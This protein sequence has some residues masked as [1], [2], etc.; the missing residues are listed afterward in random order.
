MEL[1]IG[2]VITAYTELGLLFIYHSLNSVNFLP[3]AKPNAVTVMFMWNKPS[4][5]PD[6]A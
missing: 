6:K 4:L 3:I 2:K 5:G 1:K